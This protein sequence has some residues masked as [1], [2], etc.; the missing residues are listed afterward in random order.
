M[1]SISDTLLNIWQDQEK[2]NNHPPEEVN[3]FNLVDEIIQENRYIAA[4]PNINII[5]NITPSLV[6]SL[7]KQPFSII[8]VNLVKN[9]LQ[10][11]HTGF[12]R[13][14]IED[15]TL[16]VT[17]SYSINTANKQAAFPEYGFGLGLFI[18]KTVATQQSWRLDCSQEGS[19]FH[20]KFI[21]N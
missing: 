18:A 5:V 14:D 11:T 13:I 16:V 7:A 9:A 4:N 21:F 12:I 3:I 17:N 19:E 6:I 10:Y 2:D 15:R 1:I 20:S 8:V